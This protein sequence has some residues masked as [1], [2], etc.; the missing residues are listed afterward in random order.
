M[1]SKTLIKL[2][3]KTAKTNCEAAALAARLVMDAIRPIM[4]G[5]EMLRVADAMERRRATGAHLAGDYSAFE[6]LRPYAMRAG[7]GGQLDR[8]IA[9]ALQCDRLLGHVV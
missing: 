6:V 8:C 5:A 4:T 7:V 2:A 3:R 9:M 1:R